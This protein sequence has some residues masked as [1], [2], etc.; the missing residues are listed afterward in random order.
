MKS[1]WVIIADD[2]TGAGDSAVQFGS[3]GKRVRLILKPSGNGNRGRSLA[4]I[5]VDTDTRFLSPNAAYDRVAAATHEL[6]AAGSRTFFK[7]IDST[8]RGNPADEI[9][10]V[11]DAASYRFAVVAPSA[12]RNQR[13]V[14]NGLC[15]VAGE[16]LANSSVARDP[17]TP[18][19][20]ARVS[21]LM[22]RRFP[23][24]VHELPLELVR[25]G[26][27]K[28]L[29][30]I[31]EQLALGTRLFVADA[32]TME[33]L[34][35]VASLSSLDGLLFV[36]SSGLA[37]AL[38]KKDDAVK[39]ALPRFPQGRALFVIGSVTP[40]SAA[41]CDRLVRKAG[42]VEIVVL[43]AAVLANPAEEKRRLLSLIRA[44]SKRHALLIRTSG[45]FTPGAAD[46]SDKNAG[47][48]ISRFLGELTLE[49]ARVR[50]IRFLFASGGDTAARIAAA[51]GAESIDFISEILPGLPFGFFRSASLERRMYFV[52][53]SGG[54]GDQD[55]MAKSLAMVSTVPV[56]SKEKKT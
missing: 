41:Q 21:K 24:A 17:F 8:L 44:A 38:A 6:Y 4:A 50:K 1:N 54:F 43:S 18:V 13:T 32:E 16:P 30:K 37:E 49:A 26:K 11:M 52:S 23:G 20:E 22:E 5:V 45:S 3:S 15:Y 14:V 28:L 33:D 48:L 12:P 10:A 46:L 55:A 35:S 27:E 56:Y 36:G 19:T 9:A 53:K 51:L 7:K 39:P 2:F 47:V 25:S 34:R 29:A 31:N 40:T 42:A